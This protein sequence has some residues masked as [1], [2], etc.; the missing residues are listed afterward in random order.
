MGRLLSLET[1]S[2]YF[3]AECGIPLLCTEYG[4]LWTLYAKNTR[5]NTVVFGAGRVIRG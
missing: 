3:A 1:N 4:V 2:P 5:A